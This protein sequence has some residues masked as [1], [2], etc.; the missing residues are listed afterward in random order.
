MP[1][2]KNSLIKARLNFKIKK[3]L[4][5]WVF[6][7]AKRNNISVTAMIEDYFRALRDQNEPKKGVRKEEVVEQ[8]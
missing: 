5:D 8:I 2:S 3:D 7:Y 1:E 4:R 6:A